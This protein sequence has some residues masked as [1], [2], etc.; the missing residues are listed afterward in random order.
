MSGTRRTLLAA[1][2]VGVIVLTGCV[3]RGPAQAPGAAPQASATASKT[4]SAPVSVEP[5][6]A[7]PIQ[8]TGAVTSP[9]AGSAERKALLDAARERLATKSQF[10]VYQLYAQGDTALGDIEPLTKSAYG[11]I[12][13]AWE[14]SNGKW[15]AIGATKFGSAAATAANTARALPSFSTELI[16]KMDWSLP[17]PAPASSGSASSASMIKS[18]S[19]A[20]K[21]WANT[22]M[23]GKGTPY[24]I[25]SVKVAQ[26]SKGTWWGHVV[27]QPTG[28][29]SNSYEALDYWAKYTGGS[30]QGKLQDPEPPAP[31]TYFP[32][33][34]IP[35]LGL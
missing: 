5:T 24:N 20:A 12:V 17:K 19:A 35:K 18:L 3:N 22:P 15:A 2:L 9:A 10:Y 32:S 27:V 11:R 7:V 8:T 4:A 14:R 25:A 30:W 33:S 29:A 34:V 6:R 26:D 23:D 31:S 16:N 21:T 13:V 1:A 28:D